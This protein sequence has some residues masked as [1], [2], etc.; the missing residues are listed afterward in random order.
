MLKKALLF[1]CIYLAAFSAYAELKPNSV[2]E[3]GP[4]YSFAIAPWKNNAKGAYSIIFDDYCVDNAYGIQD[5]VER[6][7]NAR[8]IKI[9]FAVVA[10]NCEE[11]EWQRAREMIA[12]GHEVINHSWSHRCGIPEPWCKEFNIDVWGKVDFDLEIDQATDVIE[13]NTRVRPKFYVFPY[14]LFTDGMIVRLKEL[15]YWG[16]RTGE[17]MKLTPQAATDPYA[18]NYDVQFP[19]GSKDQQ[20]YS[21]NEYV[22][23]A[24]ASGDLALRELHGV[25]DTSWGSISLKTLISHFEHIKLKIDLHAIWV[26]PISEIILYRHARKHCSIKLTKEQAVSQMKISGD[27]EYCKADVELSVLAKG[28]EAYILKDAS[29]N[30][31][32]PVNG[33]YTLKSN[34]SYS[35]QPKA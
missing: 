30:E 13:K 5:H 4:D 22:D 25:N 18:L 34:A 10:G 19:E 2:S 31:I 33:A 3:K 28:F 21:L 12:N 23:A 32:R 20:A 29:G 6:E 16:A 8:G 1:A 9:G 7:A 27:S 15:G 17:K 11:P 14:D 24:I 35:I 26:A